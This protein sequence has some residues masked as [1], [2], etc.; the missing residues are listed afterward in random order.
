MDT[1]L[2]IGVI[3]KDESGQKI[4]LIKEKL[5]KKDRP[6]WN[7]IK[8]TYGDNGDESVFEAATRECLEETST[9]VELIKTLGCYVSKN[10]EKTR[11]QF[12]FLAKIISGEPKLPEHE[13]QATRD[14][15]ISDIKWFNKD[16]ISKMNPDEFVSNRAYELIMSYLEGNEFPIEAYKQVEM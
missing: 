11:I 7:I 3:I 8:G 2:K 9:N 1:K 6:L 12:N 10:G 5:A 15:S 13:D 16:E 14:E 4:L